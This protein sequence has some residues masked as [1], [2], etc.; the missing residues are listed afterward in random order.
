MGSGFGFAQMMKEKNGQLTSAEKLTL[1][2]LYMV[3]TLCDSF[4]VKSQEFS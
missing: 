3:I 2:A 4:P 1:K